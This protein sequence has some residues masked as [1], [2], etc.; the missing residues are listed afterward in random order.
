MGII[1]LLA[2][3]T[4]VGAWHMPRTWEPEGMILT[5]SVL[6]M[7]CFIVVASVVVAVDVIRTKA[8]GRDLHSQTRFGLGAVLVALLICPLLLNASWKRT[9]QLT[10]GCNLFNIGC[11]LRMYSSDWDGQFPPWDGAA[12]LELLRSQGYCENWKFYVC[13]STETRGADG[14]ALTEETVDYRYF[15]G[16]TEA[17]GI[18]IPFLCDK[19]SN[20]RNYGNVVFPNGRIRV[21]DFAGKEWEEIQAQAVAMHE[22]IVGARRAQGKAR[23]E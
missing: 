17:D 1:C 19:A 3:G 11:A 7:C 8:K 9:R 15:G 4:T 6:A 21:E 2:A 16:Y 14:V 10:C 18:D 23:A 20:H 13:P 5:L 12:G 22:R